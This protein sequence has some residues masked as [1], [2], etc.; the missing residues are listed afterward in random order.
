MK[1]SGGER[2]NEQILQLMITKLVILDEIY[3]KD[4]DVKSCI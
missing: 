3:P 2:R 4:I 1:V